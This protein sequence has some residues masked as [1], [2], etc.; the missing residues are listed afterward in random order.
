LSFKPPT[1]W[2][3]ESDT[4]YIHKSLVRIEKRSYRQ[5]DGWFV[6]PTDIKEEVV[7]FAPTVEGRDKAFEHFAKEMV[8]G[9]AKAAPKAKPR[10]RKTVKKKKVEPEEEEA[11]ED[12]DDEDE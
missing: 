9:K 12:E 8:R 1:G 3:Q 5:Q 10:K 11:N 6:I 2:K 7:G 4:L